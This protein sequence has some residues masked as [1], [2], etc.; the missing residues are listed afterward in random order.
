MYIDAYDLPTDLWSIIALAMRRVS[1]L[2][3]KKVLPMINRSLVRDFDESTCRHRF[4]RN[5]DS[6]SN[7]IGSYFLLV[8]QEYR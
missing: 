1:N 4:V 3:G 8:Y 5:K 2:M 6:S 7:I